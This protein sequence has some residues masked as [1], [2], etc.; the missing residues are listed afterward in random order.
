MSWFGR[1]QLENDTVN[2]YLSRERKI[3][4]I[5]GVYRIWRVIYS[6]AVCVR[7]IEAAPVVAYCSIIPGVG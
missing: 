2:I 5:V 3:V 4:L 6:V 7:G 1:R